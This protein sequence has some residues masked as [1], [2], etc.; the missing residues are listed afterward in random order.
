[1]NA[2]S[3]LSELRKRDIH[4]RLDGDRL[5]CSAPEG[6]LNPVLREQLR[7][8]KAELIE[9]LRQAGALANQ[10]R[11]IV[12]LMPGA[13]RVPIFAVPGHNGDVFC[14][15]WL[16]RALGDTQPFYG[17][18]PPGL[19]GGEPLHSITRLAGYFADQIC[20][21]RPEG[22]Y[23]LAGYCAGGTIAFELARQ[24]AARGKAIRYLALFASPYPRWW[25]RAAQYEYRL[26]TEAV[27]LGGHLRAVA[28]RPGNWRGYLDER[29][30]QHRTR[31]EAELEAQ[32]IA[33]RDPLFDKKQRLE[34]VTLAAA[35]RYQPAFYPGRISFFLAGVDP[36]AGD[37]PRWSEIAG[38]L[39]RYEG[40]PGCD[41]DWMLREP[42]VSRTAEAVR[43]CIEK[44]E[45]DRVQAS[46][47]QRADLSGRFAS[48]PG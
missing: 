37:T 1:M 38:E 18:Q 48:V 33:Q 2:A 11:A 17:L 16:A 20:A 7:A 34:R 9:F 31:I 47:C 8:H 23:A 36:L 39:D 25:S 27:R 45:T 3:L 44:S 10:Q 12:P 42:Y 30:R 35:G 4:I 14:Y 5:H 32:R 24:L 29:L 21:F 43:C 15:R 46:D 19:D 28:V 13:K 40:V 26:R 22:P 41:R 6:A